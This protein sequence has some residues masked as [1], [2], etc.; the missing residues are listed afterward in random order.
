MCVHLQEKVLWFQ[1]LVHVGRNELKGLE[2]IELSKPENGSVA[3]FDFQVFHIR[4]I[5]LS[6][7]HGKFL[8]F[9]LCTNSA[10]CELFLECM[11][12]KACP[13]VNLPEVDAGE[14][15]EGLRLLASVTS[16]GLLCTDSRGFS[17]ELECLIKS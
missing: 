9:G 2:G 3:N 7:V 5:S 4:R 11:R 6:P 14:A 16:G 12:C 17:F 10:C 1:G 8:N 15:E 13:G